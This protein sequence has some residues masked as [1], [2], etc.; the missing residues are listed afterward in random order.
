[1]AKASRA[2]M[3]LLMLDGFGVP[4]EGWAK[5]VYAEIC[6][7]PFAK[8]FET[9]S[10]PLDACLGVE[11]IPQSAT[12]QTTLFTGVNAAKEL[13]RHMQGFP[14]PSLRA[15][16]ERGSLFSKA[17]DMGLRPGF[18]NSYVKHSLEDLEKAGLRSVTT[19]M[20]AKALGGVFA[21]KDLL[22]RKALYHDL[23]R[24]GLAGFGGV[25][26]VSPEAAAADLLRISKGFDLTLFEYFLT[27]R[28]GHKCDRALLEKALSELGRF[29]MALAGGLDGETLVITSDHGNCEDL[30]TKAHTLNPVPL[31]VLGPHDPRKLEKVTAIDDVMGFV[32][33]SLKI[34]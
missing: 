15:I 10:K 32:L 17:I 13:G 30:S 29:I 25:P 1:M 5:S 11:G 20:V 9:H 21:L 8:L 27:D 7:E 24:E 16:I 31:L 4:P 22:E 3:I 33:D 23:T 2:K 6:G 26:C 28:A 12:G 14:G 34:S 18:A 19:V